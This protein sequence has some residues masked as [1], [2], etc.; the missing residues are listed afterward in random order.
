M[1]LISERRAISPL[2]RGQRFQDGRDRRRPERD[3]FPSG[4]RRETPS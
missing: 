2:K 1:L 3:G 4:R